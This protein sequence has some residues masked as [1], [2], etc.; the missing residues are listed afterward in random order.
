M[1][2]YI[3]IAYIIYFCS[4]C[5]KL[6]YTICKERRVERERI[7]S[8]YRILSHH[9]QSIETRHISTLEMIEEVF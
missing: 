4:F 3:A 2:E 6:G 8:E 5:F 7:L 9:V 1:I